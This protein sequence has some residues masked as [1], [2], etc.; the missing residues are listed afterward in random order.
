MYAVKASNVTMV[1]LL[2]T[3]KVNIRK[4]ALNGWNALMYTAFHGHEELF[5]MLVGH[6]ATL[7]EENEVCAVAR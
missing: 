7:T 1:Q 3:Y 5:R 6:G 4:Q 2:L